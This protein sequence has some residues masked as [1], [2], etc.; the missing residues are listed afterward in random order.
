MTFGKVNKEFVVIAKLTNS[1]KPQM[2]N[3]Q[4]F[5]QLGK[6]NGYTPDRTKEKVSIWVG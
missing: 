1:K 2:V 6:W 5:Y 3:G 4:P